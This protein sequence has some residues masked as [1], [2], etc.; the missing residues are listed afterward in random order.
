[1]EKHKIVDTVMNPTFSKPVL[2]EAAG[3]K[4]GVWSVPIWNL[5]ERNLNGRTYHKDLAERLVKENAITLCM[6]GHE[7]MLAEYSNAMARAFNPRI[8]NNQLVVDFEFI[9]EVYEK[10]LRKCM[11][12]NIPVGVSSVGYGTED[13]KGNIN[14]DDY[15]LVRYFDFVQHPA[16]ETY[17]SDEKQSDEPETEDKSAENEAMAENKAPAMAEE[18]LETVKA[19]RL[20]FLNLIKK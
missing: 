5:G 4:N 3:E 2:N 12:S 6:D 18:D 13:E 10:K 7:N 14:S 16:N 1:M 19:R 17:V 11:D 9:D 20:E 15:E 8:E